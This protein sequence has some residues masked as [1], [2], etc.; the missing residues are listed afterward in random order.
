MA[1][2]AQ[3]SVAS[4]PLPDLRSQAVGTEKSVFHLRRHNDA[5]LP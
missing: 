4:H 5:V 1:G 2:H 3:L